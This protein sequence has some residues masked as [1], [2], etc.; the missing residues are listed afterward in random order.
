MN[1]R[2]I[3]TLSIITVLGLAMVPGTTVAQQRALKDQLVGTWMLVSNETGPLNGT[4]RQIANPKGILMLDAG[5]RYALFTVRG[6]RPK[7][8]SAGAPTT[9]E[10]ATTVRDYVAGNFGTWSVNEADKTLTR[11]YDAALNP[12]N[13][14]TE[15]KAAVSVSGDEVRLTTVTPG[16]SGTR[17]DSVY[18]RAR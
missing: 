7:Y 12:N 14:G 15:A 18:R 1:R 6:D 9:E 17:T 8:K 10:I 3:F 13:E 11:R 5:G 2:S 16:G 4:K